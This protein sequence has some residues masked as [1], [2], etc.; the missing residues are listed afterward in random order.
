MNDVKCENHRQKI[1]WGEKS[2]LYNNTKTVPERDS[3]IAQETC[4][5]RMIPYQGQHKW[6]VS[7]QLA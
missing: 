6:D 7:I 1:I 3:L 4:I 2:S 5:R